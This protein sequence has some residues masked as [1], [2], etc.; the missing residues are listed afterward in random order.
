MP[1]RFNLFN[2]ANNIISEGN[3][4]TISKDNAP[5]LASEFQKLMMKKY[6]WNNSLIIELTVSD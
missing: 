4:R 6:G 3:A 2:A 5:E 1:A